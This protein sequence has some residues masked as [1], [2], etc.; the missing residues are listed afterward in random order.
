MTWRQS[1]ASSVREY[2]MTERRAM[3]WLTEV[4]AGYG[5]DVWETKVATCVVGVV[6]VC[7]L[8]AILDWSGICDY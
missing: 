1:V 3:A 8:M 4:G 5:L 7:S 6:I 2:E